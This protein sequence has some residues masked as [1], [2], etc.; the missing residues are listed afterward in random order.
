MPNRTGDD[1][2]RL[3]ARLAATAILALSAFLGTA[4]DAGARA[5]RCFTSDDGFYD[6]DFAT[7]PRGGF[8]IAAPG[9]PTFILDI[10]RLGIALG[11][12]GFGDRNVPLPGRYHRS[13]NDQACWDND[14]TGTRICAW[15]RH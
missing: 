8:T 9:K 7:G 5:A 1:R 10:E 14:A 15:S 2:L 12:V 13:E 4:N 6:C 3:P 11:F